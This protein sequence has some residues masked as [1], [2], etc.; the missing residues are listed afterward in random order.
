MEAQEGVLLRTSSGN[1]VV[2]E[3]RAHNGFVS[4]AC[5]DNRID[6]DV[7][8]ALDLADVLSIVCSDIYALAGEQE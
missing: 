3:V 8:S 6:I 2:L 1:L 4:I 5:G 7:D